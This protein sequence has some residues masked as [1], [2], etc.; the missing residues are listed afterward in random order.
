MELQE[1]SPWL[2]WEEINT[3]SKSHLISTWARRWSKNRRTAFGSVEQW[4]WQNLSLELLASGYR[5][6]FDVRMLGFFSLSGACILGCWLSRVPSS[7]PLVLIN[8]LPRCWLSHINPPEIGKLHSAPVWRNL[9]WVLCGCMELRNV[10]GR[11]KVERPE[12]IQL[13]YHGG[14]FMVCIAYIEICMKFKNN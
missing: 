9:N 13:C 6:Q 10:D 4:I 1:C 5:F 12:I 14:L 2:F 3:F 7:L 8:T 11:L